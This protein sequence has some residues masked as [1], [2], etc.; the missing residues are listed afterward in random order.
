[1]ACRSR[2]RLRKNGRRQTTHRGPGLYG[3]G[4]AAGRVTGLGRTEKLSV[5]EVL[6]EKSHGMCRAML[7]AASVSG[8][9]PSYPES[10]YF[11]VGS[12]VHGFTLKCVRLRMR[13]SHRT[14]LR[15]SF[16]QLA[17]AMS[18]LGRSAAHLVEKAFFLELGRAATGIN[19]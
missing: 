11:S 19:R 5:E 12:G 7:S 14:R 3:D 4:P 1:M 13:E 15:M 17:G 10:R 9:Y 6:P 18:R 2:V 8:I 16:S